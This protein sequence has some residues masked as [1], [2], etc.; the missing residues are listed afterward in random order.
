MLIF[1]HEAHMGLM[2]IVIVQS[3]Y[4]GMQSKRPYAASGTVQAC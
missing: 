4:R 3:C 2:E 1:K